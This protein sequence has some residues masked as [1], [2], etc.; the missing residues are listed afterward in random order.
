M[1]QLV[2]GIATKPRLSGNILPYIKTCEN[3]WSNFSQNL[4]NHGIKID[5]V[6]SIPLTKSINFELFTLILYGVGVRRGRRRF[7]VL[8]TFI[9]KS[10]TYAIAMCHHFVLMTIVVILMQQQHV[11]TLL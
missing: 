4:R 2:T 8:S 5:G 6:N 3:G 1:K 11:I 10:M 9:E 7:S